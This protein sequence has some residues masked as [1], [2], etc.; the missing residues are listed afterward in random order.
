[1]KLELDNIDRKIQS[2]TLFHPYRDLRVWSVERPAFRQFA[3]VY[4]FF[5]AY[6]AN[7][8]WEIR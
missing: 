3:A 8:W 1:M 4:N 6:M 5:R 2:E 7:H